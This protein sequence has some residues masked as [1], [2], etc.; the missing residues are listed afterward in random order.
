MPSRNQARI[1]FRKKLAEKDLSVKDLA[2]RVGYP[3]ETVSRAIHHQKFPR[4]LAKIREVL[5]A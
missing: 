3:R 2:A 1:A 5:Y 4:V